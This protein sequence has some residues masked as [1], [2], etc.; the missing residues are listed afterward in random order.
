MQH[1]VKSF[2]FQKAYECNMKS[3]T[4][5]CI[6]CSICSIC[7]SIG[8]VKYLK[9]VT[10]FCGGWGWTGPRKFPC[11]GE[12]LFSIL[13]IFHIIDPPQIFSK[14]I[15]WIWKM[16]LFDFQ[17]L[18]LLL[19]L[20]WS[21]WWDTLRSGPLGRCNNH[22]SKLRSVFLSL[23]FSAGQNNLYSYHWT[24]NVEHCYHWTLNILIILQVCKSTANSKK[25]PTFSIS[26]SRFWN[27]S[28]GET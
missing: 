18:L 19:L 27:E 11:F 12:T 20:L 5:L 16:W 8:P 17:L 21:W 3:E 9:W 2:N 25:Y 22:S 6:C 28:S 10:I 7:C 13:I 4:H 26:K 23:A 24:L 14:Q 1:I 15:H